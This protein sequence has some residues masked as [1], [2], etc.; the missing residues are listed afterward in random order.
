MLKSYADDAPW[1]ENFNLDKIVTLIDVPALDFLL[2]DTEYLED[3]CNFVIDGFKLG[4]TLGYD[5]PKERQTTASNLKLKCGN[6]KDVWSKVMKEVKLGRFAGPF[7]DISY[8]IY[9]QSPIGLVPKHEPGE[10]RLIFHLSYP[11]EDSVNSHTPHK[12]CTVKYKDLDHVFFFWKFP[13]WH[14]RQICPWRIV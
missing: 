2:Q 6:L 1:E 7:S 4:F 14:L 11:E 8:K 12:L 13:L 9:V 10:T 3:E 5:G